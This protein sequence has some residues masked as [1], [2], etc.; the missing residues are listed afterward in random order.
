MAPVIT[1]AHTEPL[2]LLS[3]GELVTTGQAE[4]KGLKNWGAVDVVV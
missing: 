2:D 3:A 1:E 4:S